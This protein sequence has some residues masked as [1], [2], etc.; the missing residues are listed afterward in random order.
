MKAWRM[1]YRRAAFWT[2]TLLIL[3]LCIG[4]FREFG[5]GDAV[6]VDAKPQ[7]SLPVIMYHSILKDPQR[8]GKFVVSPMV[9]EEDLRYL[10]EAGYT[11]VT[12]KDLADY[13]NYGKPLPY[14]P[15]LISLDDGYYNNM[16]YVLPI[17]EKLNMKAVISVVGEYTERFSTEEDLN[18]NYSHLCWNDIA[19]LNN[20]G[21][22]E[23]QNHSYA[24]HTDQNGRKGSMRK[25][26]ESEA[27]YAA[28]FREDTMRLQHLL[29]EHCGFLPIAYTYPYGAVSEESEVYLKEMG[30]LASLICYE[31]VNTITR[32]PECL[33]GLGRY[34]RPSGI[35]TVE[36]MNK[37]GITPKPDA[38]T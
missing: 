14:K 13:V 7:I 9:F 37:I 34:N 20:S 11:T 29:E 23:I 38:D 1:L 5:M 4:L 3:G 15:V 31:K 33:F 22:V 12:V 36:F 30:F 6:P 18:P 17:L 19:T 25:P 35:G 28:I 26:G 16:T 27:D 2:F 10:K 8:A 24:L 21:L 32:D